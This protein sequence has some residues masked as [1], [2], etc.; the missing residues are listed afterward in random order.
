MPTRCAC[1]A[2]M[3]ATWLA[4]CASPPP[5]AADLV[6]R[7]GRLLTMD[8]ARPEA[9]ALA[10][11]AGRI[12]F[13]GADADVARY[14][15]PST[16]TVDLQGRLAIPGF[17]EAHGH[18]VGLGESKLGLD[19]TGT[20]SWPQIVQAVA[21]AV[22]RARPGQ[23]I[24][25]RGW[26]QDKWTAVPE[27][28]VEGFPT[29][30]SLDAV[31]PDNP[32]VLVHASGHGAFVNARALALSGITRATSNPPGGDILKDARGE[33]AGFLR[34]NA[35]QL[36][37]R[38]AGEP[39]P[40]VAEVASRFRD[41]LRLADQEAISKGVTSFQDAGEPFGT[42]DALRSAVDRGELRVRLWV[43]VQGRVAELSDALARYKAIGYGND[44]LTVRAIKVYADGA[45][46]SRGAWLLQPYADTPES[47]GLPRPDMATL[48]QV[49]RLAI[50]QGYQLAVHAIGDRAN[51][52]VLNV[53]EAALTAAGRRGVDLRWRI[54]HA[55]QLNAADIPRFG[56]IGVI[57]S[58][59]PV[60]A[61]SDGSWVGERIGPAR[62]EE[63][64]YVWRKLLASG[65]ALAVGT[66]VP[67]EDVDPIANYYAAVT[68]RL[69]DGR[70][71]TGDQRLTRL[72]ALR[73]F[74]L[75]N[76]FAAFEESIKGSLSVGKLAD[77]TVLS[78]DITAVPDDEI[79][80]ARVVYTI[81]G[82]KVRY[83]AR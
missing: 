70:V 59:Q 15:G 27:P 1:A 28:N 39:D 23:W 14:I 36:V 25:G 18:F 55:Q 78:K 66:D 83:E 72:E 53:Y 47:V 75:N 71:L 80:S 32:V 29:H 38:G 62:L 41:A 48:P 58:M 67:V 82:G 79:R 10:A 16:T 35:A 13:V 57:A 8:G 52:E 2:V 12:V 56:A 64:A 68:R 31:S 81:V 30:A 21:G 6:L 63:G 7:N 40:S 44:M 45:M 5:P 77:V 3:L 61:T 24:V 49:A 4:A 42:I 46:G 34:E 11:R 76:A 22:A 60:H 9:R 33:P 37:K 50:E 19:L 51:R 54:E 26:H 65:A 73:A 69:A 43:M 74:T 20:T 17:I